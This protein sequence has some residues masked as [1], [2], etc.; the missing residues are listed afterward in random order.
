MQ[1]VIVHFDKIIN[2]IAEVL[3]EG[4]KLIVKGS[5][6]WI[7]FGK[8]EEGQTVFEIEIDINN[9]NVFTEYSKNQ[10]FGGIAVLHELRANIISI[11]IAF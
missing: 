2:E 5:F 4:G 8:S 10:I 6:S 7:T 1:L 9:S 11:L 3:V